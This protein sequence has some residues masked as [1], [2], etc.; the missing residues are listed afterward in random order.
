V[1]VLMGPSGAGK[2]T[3]ADIILGLYPPDQ[4][5]VTVDGVPLA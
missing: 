1:T 4:G 3:I 5:R 2:T